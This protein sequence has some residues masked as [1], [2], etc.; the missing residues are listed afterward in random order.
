[1]L[2][3]LQ[4]VGKRYPMGDGHV[5]ALQGVTL[6]IEAG[7]FLAF[8]GPS[9]SGKTT[10]LNLVGCLDRPST[11]SI[12]LDGQDLSA[13]SRSQ[14][15]ELRAARIGFV[16]QSFNLIPVLSA[17]E[18][19]EVAL[20]L[21]GMASD[22]ARCEQ[23]LED[24]GLK[25]QIHKRPSQMSG[26]QQQRVAIA[27]AL[28]KQPALVIADEPTANLDSSNGEAVLDLM[29]AL[30]ED[31]GATFLFS[32]H[33]SIVLERVRRTVWLRDGVVQKIES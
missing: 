24:V 5:D 18:N 28:V 1:M 33:D 20:R 29:R 15:G 13:L 10:L 4:D 21:G 26:G 12:A 19:V 25:E 6:D 3:S 9:G 16:F 31:K 8:A 32:T 14:L 23:A 2:L 7:E 22:L 17:L 11:G 27:R 30:N